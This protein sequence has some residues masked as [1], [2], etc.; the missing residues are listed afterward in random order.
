LDSNDVSLPSSI[1]G[2][3]ALRQRRLDSAVGISRI[4]PQVELLLVNYEQAHERERQEDAAAMSKIAAK[5][6]YLGVVRGAIGRI[7][8]I[9]AAVT[10]DTPIE[11]AQRLYQEVMLLQEQIEKAQEVING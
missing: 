11:E 3:L 5:S 4:R 10:I 1:Y 8:E 9:K 2:L 7:K 6:F